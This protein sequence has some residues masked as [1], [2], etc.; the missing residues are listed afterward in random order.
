MDNEAAVEFFMTIFAR[1]VWCSHLMRTGQEMPKEQ[2]DATLKEIVAKVRGNRP[3]GV[4]MK[5]E[6]FRLIFDRLCEWHLEQRLLA[7]AG[8]E[9]K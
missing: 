1:I 4:P 3:G 2:L 5:Q 9:R 8:E 7:A 6:D